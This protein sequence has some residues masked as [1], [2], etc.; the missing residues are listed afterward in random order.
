MLSIF[1]Y[2]LESKECNLKYESKNLD[3]KILDNEENTLY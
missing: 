2:T 3:L 1:I